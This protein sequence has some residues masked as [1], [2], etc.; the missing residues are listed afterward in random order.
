MVAWAAGDVG[1]GPLDCNI[2][3]PRLHTGQALVH[4][5]G[6][7]DELCAVGDLGSTSVSFSSEVQQYK[8]NCDRIVMTKEGGRGR[9]GALGGPSMPSARAGASQKK[10]VNKSGR[11]FA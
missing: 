4:M 2:T 5:A 1:D 6:A 8:P 3:D 9:G 11:G 7:D 10:G